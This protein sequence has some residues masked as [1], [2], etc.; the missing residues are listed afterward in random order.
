[1]I[2]EIFPGSTTLLEEGAK[3]P[4]GCCLL[5]G[6]PG[7]GKSLFCRQF[8]AMSLEDGKR[9]IAI[10][11]DEPPRAFLESLMK[12]G[13]DESILGDESK[14][15]IIDAYSWRV[16]P[17]SGKYSV[18]GLEALHEVSAMTDEALTEV[19]AEDG[20]FIF[21]SLNTVVINSGEESAL[22]LAQSLM[23]R[24]AAHGY[25]G[26]ITL[27]SGIHS[28]LFESSLR[29]LGMGVVELSIEVAPDSIRRRIRIPMFQAPHKGYPIEFK[30]IDGK[31]QIT[32]TD[33]K[34]G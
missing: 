7:S 14:L 25:F 11:T 9:V 15:R 29:S 26:F 31:I 8:A 2:R 32:C 27:T 5:V 30:I 12:Y 33:E 20:R 13:V 24:V 4:R 10:L 17:V 19:E 22:L 34:K 3:L 21:D 28:G 16:G 6:P 18:S 1:M 23:A